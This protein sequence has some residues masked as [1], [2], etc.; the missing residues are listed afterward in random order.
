MTVIVGI[1]DGRTVWMGADSYTGNGYALQ[2]KGSKI[3]RR[4]LKD[5]STIL[6]GVAGEMRPMLLLDKMALPE[7]DKGMDAIHY[8]GLELVEAMRVEFAAAGFATTADGRDTAS[9]M[10]VLIGYDGRVFGL[11]HDYTLVETAYNYLA[12]GSGHVHRSGRVGRDR[13]D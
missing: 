8:V 2:M 13:R 12:L 4:Q 7:H 5:G 11:W 9:Q 6:F 1:A 10:Q 3:V